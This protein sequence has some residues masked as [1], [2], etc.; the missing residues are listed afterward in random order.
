MDGHTYLCVHFRNRIA[1]AETGFL[2]GALISRFNDNV[3]FHNHVGG[4]YRYRYP[5]VQYK[6]VGG[7]AAVVGIDEGADALRPLSG[8]LGLECRLGRRP[9]SLEVRSVE[10]GWFSVGLSD[11][12]TRY[13]IR[14]W[15]P[16][17]QDNYRTFQSVRLLSDRVKMLEKI[18]VSNILSFSKGIGVYW[19]SDIVC[20]LLDMRMGAPFAYKGVELTSVDA[21][22]ETNVCGLP[23]YIGLGKGASVG[24]GVIFR[25]DSRVE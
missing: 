20:N 2:R 18:L 23:S 22:F 12:M 6:S 24:K 9:V 15:L 7:C 14:N 4:N 21:V 11:E 17:N 3:L 25:A 19:E 1:P 8:S 16:L 10:S 13:S 5:L